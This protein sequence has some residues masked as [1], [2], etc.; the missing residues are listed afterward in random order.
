MEKVTTFLKHSWEEVQ[1][2]VTWPKFSDLQAS[3]SLVLIASLIFALM[4]GLI[5]YLFENG[6][7]LFY[8]SF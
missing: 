1:H 2:N 5:D 4:V 8:Q 7:N 3:S 6:L